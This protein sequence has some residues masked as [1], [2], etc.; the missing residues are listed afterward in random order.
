MVTVER[1]RFEVRGVVQ[2]VGFRPFV[3]GLAQRNGLSGFV[4]ND[5]RGV[6]IEAEGESAALAAF[7]VGLRAEAPP[8]ARVDR[9]TVDPL[10]VRGQA[11]FAIAASHGGAATALIPADVATCGD[12]LRELFD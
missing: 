1:R 8:L 4:L 2:G 3:Y 9:V 7:E 12:C 11:G 5:G 10:S 6:V